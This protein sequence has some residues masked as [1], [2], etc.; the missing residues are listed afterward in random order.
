MVEYMVA[1]GERSAKTAGEAVQVNI[2]E[3]QVERAVE[4]SFNDVATKTFQ[5]YDQMLDNTPAAQR[6]QLLNYIYEILSFSLSEEDLNKFPQTGDPAEATFRLSQLGAGA[7]RAF[8]E[9]ATGMRSEVEDSLSGILSEA[10]NR[11]KSG[12][13]PTVEFSIGPFSEEQRQFAYLVFDA[14]I[15]NQSLQPPADYVSGAAYSGSKRGYSS[16]DAASR[17]IPALIEFG[18]T[19]VTVKWPPWIFGQTYAEQNM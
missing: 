18:L 7:E 5:M 15:T 10:I 6:G 12:T 4:A 3:R 13:V 8:S 2:T 9:W 1:R 17:R 16:D 14:F 11:V 19:E